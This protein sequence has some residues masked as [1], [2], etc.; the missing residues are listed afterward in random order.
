MHFHF[1][2]TAVEVLWTLT[3]AGLLVLLV[4]LLGR[5]RAR[6]YPWFTVSMVL[7][8]LRLLTSRLLFGRMAP[9]T[10][11]AISIMLTDV[12]AIVGVLVVVE[13][14][15]RGFEGAQRRAWVVGTVAL[16]AVCGGLL[17]AWGPWPAWKAVTEAS[18]LGILRL[19]QLVAQKGNLLA[20]MMMVGLGLLV[21]LF[22]R[23]YKAGWSSHTQRIVIGLSTASMAQIAVEVIWREIAVHARPRSMAEYHHILG[24]QE[25]L[26][27]AN[28]VVYLGVLVWWIVCL[29]KD[30]A[31]TKAEGAAVVEIRP[32]A[33]DSPTPAPSN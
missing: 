8:A 6:R 27:N 14:A 31:G 1:G 23:R 32:D 21:M 33:P 22:G 16:V 3:F 25:K 10:L 12:T 15:R 11:S 5:D 28:S 4:V 17:V 18:V 26:F 19:M 2:F 30:E 29:W 7:M 13:M 9:I 24:M 20:D